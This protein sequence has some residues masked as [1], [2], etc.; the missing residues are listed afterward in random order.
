MNR[1]IKRALIVIEI[2]GGFTGL[3]F[4]LREHPWNE[5]IPLTFSI[6]TAIFAFLYIFGITAGLTLVEWPRLGIKLSLIYQILQI[7]VISSPILTYVFVSGIRLVVGWS[8][9]RVFVL[10]EFGSRIVLY[11]MRKDPW[12]VGIN[13]LALALFVYLLLQ[14]RPKVKATEPSSTN[15][16][17]PQG[18]KEVSRVELK[19]SQP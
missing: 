8:G 14:L 5:T 10:Y 18:D 7:P 13:V 2:G 17:S 19:E 9:G 1:W 11:L 12:V 6:F 15:I 4:L 3:V 16:N